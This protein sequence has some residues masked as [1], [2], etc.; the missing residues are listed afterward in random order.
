MQDVINE[1]AGVSREPPFRNKLRHPPCI[2][3]LLRHGISDDMDTESALSIIAR[4]AAAKGLDEKRETRMV[5][6]MM[7]NT[8]SLGVGG[9]KESCRVQ[10]SHGAKRRD[11]RTSTWD[12]Q[13]VLSSPQLR[14]RA[15][16]GWRCEFYSPGESRGQSSQSSAEEGTVERALLT[17]VFSNPEGVIEGLRLKLHSES[18]TGTY[19][20]RDGM[21]LPLHR[22]LWHVCCHLT[23]QNN[24][25]RA[26]RV[27]HLLSRYAGMRRHLTEVTRY[28]Q[29]VATSTSCRHDDFIQHVLQVRE[30]GMEQHVQRLISAASRAL[31]LRALPIDIILRTLEEQAHVLS[32]TIDGALYRLDDDLDHLVETFVSR[33]HC[34]TPTP[35]MWLN[36]TLGGGWKPGS[37]YVVCAARETEATDF[38]A[39]CIDHAAWCNHPTLHVNYGNSRSEVGRV[40]LARHSGIGSNEL[41]MRGGRVYDS[42]EREMQLKRL[43]SGGEHFSK[44]VAQH[45]WML[46]ADDQTA[47]LDILRAARAVQQHGGSGHG[48]PTLLLIDRL[49]ATARGEATVASGDGT[50]RLSEVHAALA[51]LKRSTWNSSVAVIAVVIART[52]RDEEGRKE[53]AN[54]SSISL[55]DCKNSNAA[56]Y[57]LTIHPC[58]VAIDGLVGKKIVDQLDVAREWYKRRYPLRRECIHRCFDKLRD[59]HRTEAPSYYVRVSLCKRR[60]AVSSNP[61][62]LY[63]PA[64]R[65]FHPLDIEPKNFEEVIRTF[66]AR[67]DDTAPSSRL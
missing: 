44:R 61:L 33:A 60:G 19:A 1:L 23:R 63:E 43:V 6:L 27:L 59:E 38:V 4:Y 32:S 49:L 56:D 5:H 29:D 36:S 31:R 62:T 65:R 48:K 34:V 42:T 9:V 39:W 8:P 28:V 24:E 64:L 35:S 25:I 58:N 37:V 13:E 53:D 40:M 11:C 10:Q 54:G 51:G 46:E 52:A 21:I 57:T 66:P 17:Y 15:C 12:C 16:N 18:F 20:C 2:H 7:R 50:K 67:Y 14:E 30:R 22:A 55:E 26:S 45:S 41:S 3:F 47:I